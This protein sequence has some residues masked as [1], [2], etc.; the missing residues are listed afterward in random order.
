MTIYEYIILHVR[1]R[2]KRKN[3]LIQNQFG[4]LLFYVSNF[5]RD[6]ELPN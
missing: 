4:S 1:S 3:L 2:I 5:V 6:V